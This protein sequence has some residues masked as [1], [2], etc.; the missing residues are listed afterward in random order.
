MFRQ[1]VKISSLFT[2]ELFTAKVTDARTFYRILE[3]YNFLYNIHLS[4]FLY[5]INNKLIRALKSSLSNILSDIFSLSLKHGYISK[6]WKQAA[7]LL[8]KKPDKVSTNPA[9]YRPISLL[10]CLGKL[11]EISINSKLYAWAEQN[12]KINIEQSGF[13]NHRSTQDQ[14]FRLTQQ[15]SQGFKGVVPWI[16]QK[17]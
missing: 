14:L 10:S 6:A 2:D 12:N 4:P 13:R 11:L 16:F 5:K 17:I 1:K 9:N 3:V 8:I 7:V 15:I